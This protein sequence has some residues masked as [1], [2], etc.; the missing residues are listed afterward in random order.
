MAIDLKRGRAALA[1]LPNLLI[2]PCSNYLKCKD[3]ASG[4]NIPPEAFISRS[5]FASY[6][7]VTRTAVATAATAAI[8]SGL[9]FVDI[10]CASAQLRSVELLDSSGAFFLC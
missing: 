4:E 1:H 5:L 7:L 2:S 3:K 6:G 8:F 10:Q 9:G